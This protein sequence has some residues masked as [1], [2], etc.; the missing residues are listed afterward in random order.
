MGG[1]Q[2]LG[3]AESSAVSYPCRTCLCTKEETQIISIDL[4]EKHRTKESYNEAIDIINN[5]ERIDYK[6]TK[7]IREFCVLNRLEYFHILDNLNADIMHDLCEGTVS[8]LLFH[9]SKHLLDTKLFTEQNLRNLVS[10][11]SYGVLNRHNNP[12]NISFEKRNLNQ[13]ASQTKCLLYHL[14]YIFVEYKSHDAFKDLWICLHSMLEIMTICYSATIKESYLINLEKAVK[15]HLESMVRV[16]KI[17]LIRKHHHMTHY[18]HIIR[19][20]GPLVHMSTMRFEMKHK[21]LKKISKSTNNFRNINRTITARHVERS[22]VKTMY[23]NEISHGVMRVL[24]FQL[25][26]KFEGLL[27]G[28]CEHQCDQTKWLRINSHYY[29]NGLFLKS[30]FDF[31]EI[32]HILYAENEYYFICTKYKQNGYDEFLNSIMIEKISPVSVDLLKYSELGCK[33]SFEKRS[34]MSRYF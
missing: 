9:F 29:E 5:T 25:K 8:V 7:G 17:K 33:K 22:F 27:N 13:N 24:D 2:V 30:A 26:L 15:N 18:A 19:N 31:F 11:F 12:S 21:E 10:F 1:N 28:V 32:N 14:P 34:Y 23:E 4:P 3:F 6:A 16:F 20:V